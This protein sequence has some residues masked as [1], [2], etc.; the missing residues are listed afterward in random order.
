MVQTKHSAKLCTHEELPEWAH[1]NAFILTG[2][3]RPG[4]SVQ[5]RD[6]QASAVVV[7]GGGRVLRARRRKTEPDSDDAKGPAVFQHDSYVKCIESVWKYWHNETGE[8]ACPIS[9]AAALTRCGQ[10]ST[11]TPIY[12]E[13]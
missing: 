9:L 3:R 13:L 5:W 8:C 4:G 7:D 11:F 6:D 2:Y 12:G 1:D 10:Q